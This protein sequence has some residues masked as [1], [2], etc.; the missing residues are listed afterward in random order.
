MTPRRIGRHLGEGAEPDRG[1]GS[2][3][4]D[5]LREALAAWPAGVT[6]VAVRAEGR[7]H[8]LTV[9][10]FMPVSLQPPLVLVSL[11]PNAAAAPYVAPGVELGISLLAAGQKGLASRFADT[12]P[13]GPAPFPATGAPL[14]EG[15]LAGLVCRVSEALPR[16]DH[17]LVLAEVL[18]VRTGP[19]GPALAWRHRDYRAVD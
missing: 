9:T 12:F 7:V 17:L 18:D 14:V 6:L 3:R 10:A 1:E 13:V 11:G 4:A 19:E 15:A 16:G 2:D 5:A 8:A